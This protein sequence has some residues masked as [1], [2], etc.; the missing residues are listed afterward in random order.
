MAQL[1]A[2]LGTG[3]PR[4]APSVQPN[5]PPQAT[6]TASLPA[7]PDRVSGIGACWYRVSGIAGVAL[8]KSKHNHA[9]NGRAC[10]RASSLIHS[11]CIAILSLAFAQQRGNAVMLRQASA[12]RLRNR[13]GGRH[14]AGA[15]A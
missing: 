12:R 13:A 4:Q 7:C 9:P 10:L 15:R 14:A 3:S 6:C 8:R 5:R 11:E 1:L 2:A